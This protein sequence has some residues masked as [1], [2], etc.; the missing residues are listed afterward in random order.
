MFCIQLFEVDSIVLTSALP[1]DISIV[2]MDLI[3]QTAPSVV[4]MLHNKL[5]QVQSPLKDQ[6]Q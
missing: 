1:P 3:Q 6:N 4:E 2:F 5:W